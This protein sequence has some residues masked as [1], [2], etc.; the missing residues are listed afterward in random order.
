MAVGGGPGALLA[1]GA[2][3][4]GFAKSFVMTV[5][6]EI[7]DKTFFIAAL[8]A[9]RRR[10][11]G[12][13]FLGAHGA[14]AV[15]TVLSCALGWA[16]PSV[17]P[18][19]I[20]HIAATCLFFLFSARSFNDARH[21][22][23]KAAAE[24]AEVEKELGEEDDDDA[25]KRVGPANML[26]RLVSP[27]ILQAFTL[28]FLAEWGDKSQIA[29]IGLASDEN[30]VGVSIGAVLAHGL[31]T[32]LAV[33]GGRQLASSISER[34]VALCAGLLFLGFGLHAFFTGAPESWSSISQ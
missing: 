6:S 8:L 13:V 31:C 1:G 2:W 18:P 4:E 10:R 21:A 23:T 28:T 22:S 32:G 9:M 20:A 24:L 29:T 15:M 25:K 30:P 26:S 12:L 7:G 3:Q 19:S 33:V 14:L 27:V 16:A 5:A 34:T 11:R 17:L